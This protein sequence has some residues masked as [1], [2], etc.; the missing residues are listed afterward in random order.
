MTPDV[1]TSENTCTIFVRAFLEIPGQ[2]GK[3]S[4]KEMNGTA[5]CCFPAMCVGIKSWHILG[6]RLIPEQLL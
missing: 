4:V 1:Q 5:H 6:D 3:F 2:L